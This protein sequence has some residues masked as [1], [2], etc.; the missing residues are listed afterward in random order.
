MITTSEHLSNIVKTLP[1]KPGCY[2]YFNE[3]G[4]IIYVGKAKDLKNRVSSY[5]KNSE[6]LSAKTSTLVKKIVDI[7]TI[8]VDTEWEAL[9]L[10][11]SLI[12]KHQP[13]YNI[14]LKDGKTYPWICIKHE[15]FPRVF[16][17]RNKPIADKSLYFGPYSS[18]KMAHAVIDLIKQLFKIRTCKNALSQQNIKRNKFKLCLQYHIGNCLG[19]C[20]GLESEEEYGQ[21]INMIKNLLEGNLNSITK[22]LRDQMK[23]FASNLEFEKAHVMKEKLALLDEYQSRSTVVNSKDLNL[24]VVTI[25]SDDK[26]G[27]LN[28]MKIASGAIVHSHT[29]EVQKKLNELDEDLITT[30]INDLR[31]SRISTAKELITSHKPTFTIPSVSISEPKI[32]DKRQLIELSMKNALHYKEEM[33]KRRTLVDPERHTMRILEKMKLDLHLNELPRVI[34]CFDN[35]NILG[36][37]AVA[38]MVQFKDTRPNK[39]EYRHYNIK[40]VVGANDYASMEE[41]VFRRYSRLL[42]EQ[43]PLPDLIIVDG[44][45]GQITSAV[46]SLAKLG[47]YG[48]IPLIGI[49]E[50]LEEIYFPNDSV[51][52]YLDKKSETL[53]VIQHI[54]DEAHRFG[55]THHRK[56]RSKE[57]IKTELTD[58]KGIGNTTAE[59]LLREFKSVKRIKEASFDEIAAVIGEAKAKTIVSYDL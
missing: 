54:R 27:Y 39:S 30:F 35:S 3:R 28:F 19:A 11:N 56:K 52:L 9:L 8:V 34:E 41:I 46:N 1:H 4:E 21:T 37:H 36:Q 38:A 25:V 48:K 6:T 50:K 57:T 33:D 23:G 31:E 49:A 51:P 22:E 16:L 44:G 5:F 59:L 47:L 43:K 12:K 55:I 14:L 29:I 24:D 2:Q 15:P 20:C 32:G 53:H 10:E 17:T 26:F 58:I 42:E 45:K 40:T 7:K 18:V 13:K